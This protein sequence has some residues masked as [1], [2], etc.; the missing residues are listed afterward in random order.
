MPH[1][2]LGSGPALDKDFDFVLDSSGDIKDSNGLD[3]LEKDLSF[4]S[5]FRLQDHIGT[6]LT[7]TTRQ[8][9]ENALTEVFDKEPRIDSVQEMEVEQVD[10]GF[11]VFITAIVDEE[12]Q[13]LYFPVGEYR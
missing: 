5:A 3:E 8:K 4:A 7:P 10:Y 2:N 1:R 13:A 6:P 12:R 9:V 11:D